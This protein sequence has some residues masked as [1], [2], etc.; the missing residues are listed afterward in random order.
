MA[1]KIRPSGVAYPDAV[2]E[3]SP[4]APS[5][6]LPA[7]G[8]RL[9]LVALMLGVLLGA[10]DGTMV[11]VALPTIVGDLGGVEDTHW[12]VTAYLLT[13]T[14]STLLYGRI[15]DLYGRKPVFLAAI[16]LF[17]AGSA[18]CAAAQGMGTLA[19][20]RALQGL[21]GGG[22]LTLALAVIGDV[23]PARQRAKFQGM[24]G[25][26]FGLAS[27]LG[28]V[29]G[30]PVVDSASWRWLFLLNLPIGAVVLA[31][32][33]TQLPLPVRRIEHRLDVRGAA[34]LAGA[35]GCFLCWITRGQ[36][37]GWSNAES[38]GPGAGAVVLIPAFVLSQ[39]GIPEPALPLAL[40]RNRTFALTGAVA[41]CLGTTLFAAILFVPLVLQLA[42]DRS[43]SSSGLMLAAMTTG[44]LFSSVGTGRAV[45]RSGRYKTPPIAGTALITLA[46]LGLTRLQADTSAAYTLAV[47]AVLGVGIGL[48]SPILVTVAQSTVDERNLGVATASVSFFRNLG[49]TVAG[50]VR[51][52]FRRR[53]RRGLLDRRRGRC[54][55]GGAGGAH[56]CT[57][58]ASDPGGFR[59]V[60]VALE[61]QRRGTHQ[62][63]VL[64]Q[65]RRHD[66]GGAHELH[67]GLGRVA[68]PQ[69]PEQEVARLGEAATDAHDVEVAEVGGR[70]DRDAEGLPG[71]LQGGERDGVPRARVRG[72]RRRVLAGG[73]GPAVV[74]R[75][76]RGPG[77][78]G[79][80]LEAAA[81][82][83]HALGAAW[84]HAHMAD[85]AGVA[86]ATVH[87]PPAEY[88][89]AADPRRHDHAQHVPVAPP[90]P[91]P[92][93]GDG[94]ADR[95][96]VQAH[97]PAVAQVGRQRLQPRPQRELPPGRDVQ[98]REHARRPAHRTPAADADA[99]GRGLGLAAHHR[100]EVGQRRPQHLGVRGPRRR[101]TFGVADGAVG[102]DETRRHLGAADVD[103][104]GE[105]H[106]TSQAVVRACLSTPGR[107]GVERYAL[108][109]GGRRRRGSMR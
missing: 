6:A 13:A 95:V 77:P 44:L 93:L 34:L 14:A 7:R 80:R 32:I 47:L 62:P 94:H 105:V 36:E 11:A 48:V 57:D 71:P 70:G 25:A 27:V 1:T 87:E 30:G 39:R 74:P 101:H 12:V 46:M 59:P 54:G 8:F 56:P 78:A 35:I 89:A 103:G 37:V 67:P 18:A 31:V 4:G 51:Q 16:G 99:D 63:R 45:S 76:R 106:R 73:I 82:T 85:V 20:A 9:L 22:L 49:G 19:A 72:H 52:R 53:G 98:R 107:R 66:A 50:R 38:W 5:D 55:R 81:G 88:E 41:F 15:S 3:G 24:F 65:R 91:A 33:A 69:R 68:L 21:G 60:R 108:S 104:E 83:A 100:D 64:T 26:V 28:P 79:D 92:V 61:Q 42:Q 17:L 58:A 96:V 40:F 102:V 2:N 109:R 97:R 43:A 75:P 29:V 86:A 90:R 10:L 84:V 23:V